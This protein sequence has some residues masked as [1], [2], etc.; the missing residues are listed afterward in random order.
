MTGKLLPIVALGGAVLLLSGKKKKKRA[1]VASH[2]IVKDGYSYT[3]DCKSLWIGGQLITDPKVAFGGPKIDAWFRDQALPAALKGLEQVDLEAPGMPLL[4]ASVIGVTIL[5]PEC[6][7]KKGEPNPPIAAEILGVMISLIAQHLAI[8][9][10][11]PQSVFDEMR[12]EMWVMTQAPGAGKNKL[13]VIA[14]IE[15]E[16]ANP[17]PLSAIPDSF[18]PNV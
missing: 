2:K 13:D 3:A 6:V 9:A 15:R 7:F 18:M 10:A 14:L 17:T 4:E 8:S 5:V 12:R 11:D 1:R 16:K